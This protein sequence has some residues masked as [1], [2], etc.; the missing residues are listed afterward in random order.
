MKK[1]IF[2][3]TCYVCGGQFFGTY[4]GGEIQ[5]CRICRKLVCGGCAMEFSAYNDLGTLCRK[6]AGPCKTCGGAADFFCEE[7]S[8]PLCA[9]CVALRVTLPDKE[10][11]RYCK[12][13]KEKSH[14]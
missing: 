8:E 11:K 4:I 6:C 3:A 13:C 2:S 1:E 7:C 5:W 12:D 14:A 9:A 10:E